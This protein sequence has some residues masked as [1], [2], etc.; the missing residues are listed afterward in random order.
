MN[1][2]SGSRQEHVIQ[3]QLVRASYSPWPEWLLQEWYVA[4][5]EQN[6]I[7]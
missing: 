1:S 5:S 3:A 6:G 4:Q 2:I 7:Q